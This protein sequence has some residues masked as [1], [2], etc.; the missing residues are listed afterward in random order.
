MQKNN[1]LTLDKEKIEVFREI[2]NFDNLEYLKNWK[3]DKVIVDSKNKVKKIE[4]YNYFDRL[5][6]KKL[7]KFLNTKQFKSINNNE[8]IPSLFYIL[9]S[10]EWKY[11]NWKWQILDENNLPKYYYFVD[12]VKVLK[13]RNRYILL[14]IYRNKSQNKK[15]SKLEITYLNYKKKYNSIFLDWIYW[16]RNLNEIIKRLSKRIQFIWYDEDFSKKI[17]LKEFL[18]YFLKECEYFINKWYRQKVLKEYFH[19]RDFYT[20]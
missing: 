6:L 16:L 18:N 17:T 1:L 8:K 2:K 14:K 9:L 10:K 13:H 12:L 7:I 4:V 15:F 3:F 11:T 5:N 19:S 20:K